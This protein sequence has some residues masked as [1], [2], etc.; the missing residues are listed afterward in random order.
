MKVEF[1]AAAAFG[2]YFPRATAYAW[3]KPCD[4][5]ESATVGDLLD[6]LSFP[7]NMAMNIFV[8]GRLAQ[9]PTLLSEGDRVFIK[10]TTA[11]G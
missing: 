3:D 11:G 10:P 8:N 4:I 9:R 1:K 7:A 5:A 2:R 6:S